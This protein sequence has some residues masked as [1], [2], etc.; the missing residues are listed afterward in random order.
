[1]LRS[2][3]TAWSPPVRA[4]R[5]RERV[6]RAGQCCRVGGEVFEMDRLRR[7]RRG[8]RR[9]HE[10]HERPRVA[11]VELGIASAMPEQLAQEGAN[12][13]RL[14]RVV[15][16]DLV[17][18][19]L[20]RQHIVKGRVRDRAGEVVQREVAA[21]AHEMQSHRQDR[22]D[23]DAAR[24]QKR[25]TRVRLQREVVA[26]LADVD[27]LSDRDGAVHRRG[28]AAG[29]GLPFHRD[30]IAARV[31]RAVAQRILPN[32]TRSQMHIDVRAW[33]ERRQRFARRADEIERLDVDRFVACRDDL[34]L[35]HRR[36]T[37][38]CPNGQS[39]L[40]TE[41]HGRGCSR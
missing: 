25:R 31:V 3:A 41:R 7:P 28:A 36:L 6:P 19:P 35:Q 39:R 8:R 34:R 38:R 27:R 5:N 14:D 11:Q 33:R 23:A 13:V 16:R 20:L 2:A 18:E 24:D 1:M 10:I 9:L 21:G 17:Q 26:R 32:G 22:R 4:S 37:C 40:R 12:G 30:P 29:V 15:E